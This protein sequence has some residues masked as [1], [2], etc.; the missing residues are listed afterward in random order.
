M[1][2]WLRQLARTIDA[3]LNII[4]VCVVIAGLYAAYRIATIH[5]LI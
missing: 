3:V 5:S 4:L 2:R 1:P